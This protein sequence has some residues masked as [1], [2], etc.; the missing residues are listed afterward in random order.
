MIR[1]YA[2]DTSV[3]PDIELAELECD[4]CDRRGIDKLYLL[5]HGGCACDFCALREEFTEI[6]PPGTSEE[7][8]CFCDKCGDSCGTLYSKSGKKYCIYC[9][10]DMLETVDGTEDFLNQ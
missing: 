8:D 10:L 2:P 3:Y 6:H 1:R 4:I 9:A 5:P 7:D